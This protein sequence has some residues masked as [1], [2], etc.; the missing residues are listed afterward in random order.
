MLLF[1]HELTML[2][3]CISCHL[4]LTEEIANI[5]AYALVQSRVDYANSL[6]KLSCRYSI[7]GAKVACKCCYFHWETG[8]HPTFAQRVDL[9]VP[10]FFYAISHCGEPQVHHLHL[11]LMNH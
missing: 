5:I 4:S 1:N 10:L 8:L 7:A 9:N 6:Y 11:L 2:T 3:H